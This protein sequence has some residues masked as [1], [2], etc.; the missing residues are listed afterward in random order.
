MYLY[1]KEISNKKNVYYTEN[2]FRE[3]YKYGLMK[4]LLDHNKDHYSK[5]IEIPEKVKKRTRDY[6]ESSIEIFEWLNET[7]EKTETSDYITI[8]DINLE[9]KSSEFYDSL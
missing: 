8:S 7:Y 6:M 5:K 3:K 9:L 4:I 1:K 2:E